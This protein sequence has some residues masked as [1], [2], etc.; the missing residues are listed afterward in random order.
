MDFL[1]KRWRITI[2]IFIV[3]DDISVLEFYKKICEIL[4]LKIIDKARNGQEA[5]NKFQKFITKPDLIV[6]DYH[7]PYKNGL[8]ATQAILGMDKTANIVIVSGDSTIK[9]KALASGAICFKKKPFNLTQLNQQLN[10]FKNHKKTRV[11]C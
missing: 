8:E 6:M 1:K 3:D 4:D 11:K 2:N 7:M 10:F 9:Q 5:I